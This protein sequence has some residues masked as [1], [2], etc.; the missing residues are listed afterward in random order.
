MREPVSRRLKTRRLSMN[1]LKRM[2]LIFI[3][4]FMALMLSACPP[5]M[6][7]VKVPAPELRLGL[8]PTKKQ[9]EQGTRVEIVIK[10]KTENVRCLAYDDIDKVNKYIK[11]QEVS[12]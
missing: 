9:M 6:H 5:R 3:I 12:Q 7:G 11:L 10:G 2:H 4:I 8:Y 1:G